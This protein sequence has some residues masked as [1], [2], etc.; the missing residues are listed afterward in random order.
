MALDDSSDVDDRSELGT[1]TGEEN[2]ELLDSNSLDWACNI[3]DKLRQCQAA[4]RFDPQDSWFNSSV[5]LQ[6]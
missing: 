3:I 5:E 2:V 4:G 6:P 1:E